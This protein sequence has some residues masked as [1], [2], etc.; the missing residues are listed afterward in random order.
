MQVARLLRVALG[1]VLLAGMLPAC[2]S[3]QRVALDCVPGEMTVYVDKRRLE[4]TPDEIR[5]SKNEPH[6]IFLKGGGY[7]PQMVVLE[8]QRVDGEYRLT[9]PD[10]CSQILVAEIEPALEMEV[11]EPD[12]SEGP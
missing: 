8:S 6:T 4:K 12:V 5:L 1:M 10:L 7:Q 11:E 2:A 9:P 3:K